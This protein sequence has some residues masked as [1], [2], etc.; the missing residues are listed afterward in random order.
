MA[1]QSQTT[2]SRKKAFQFQRRRHSNNGAGKF[3]A[4]KNAGVVTRLIIPAFMATENNMGHTIEEEPCDHCGKPLKIIDGVIT[5]GVS[6]VAYDS[7][8]C[9]ACAEFYLSRAS[10][11][12]DKGE[13]E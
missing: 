3:K 11:A 4:R 2:R 13:E 5:N 10:D 7:I 9:N 12:D 1:E 8:L 6:D